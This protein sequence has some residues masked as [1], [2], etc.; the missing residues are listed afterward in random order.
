M[1]QVLGAGD[2][3]KGNVSDLLTDGIR[4]VLSEREAGAAVLDVRGPVPSV[5]E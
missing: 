5:S 2:A 4:G 1:V 3:V